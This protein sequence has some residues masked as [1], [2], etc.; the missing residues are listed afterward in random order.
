[1]AVAAAAAGCGPCANLGGQHNVSVFRSEANATEFQ[2]CAQTGS[3]R[4]LCDMVFGAEMTEGF[5]L[6]ECRR[7]AF[8]PATEELTLSIRYHVS[9]CA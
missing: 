9:S 1:L 2:A 4:P 6:D 3:C 7:V 8:D 5:V